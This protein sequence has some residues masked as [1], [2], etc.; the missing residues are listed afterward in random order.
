MFT[1][2]TLQIDVENYYTF[3]GNS[4]IVSNVFLAIVQSYAG[5]C[6]NY[7]MYGGWDARYGGNPFALQKHFM[8][9]P[10]GHPISMWNSPRNET[11]GYTHM[12]GTGEGGYQG[13]GHDCIYLS[14]YPGNA[15]LRYSH[16]NSPIGYT[17][18]SRNI[19][20]YVTGQN[21]MEWRWTNCDSGQSAIYVTPCEWIMKVHGC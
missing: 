16:W 21:A 20:Q 6:L 4:Y 2:V 3:G 13:W 7:D 15:G 18:H 11:Y 8:Y 17:S 10:T 5:Y 1:D 14:L 9:W 12:F 19:Y